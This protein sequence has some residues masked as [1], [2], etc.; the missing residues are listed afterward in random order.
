MTVDDSCV[1]CQ[2]LNIPT[3]F[4]EDGSNSKEM[5]THFRNSRWR[6]PP[7]WTLANMRFRFDSC[8]LCQILNIRIEF[9]EDWSYSKEIATQFWNSK[10]RRTQCWILVIMHFYIYRFISSYLYTFIYLY[11]LFLYLFLVNMHFWTDSCVHCQHLNN[12]IKFGEDWSNS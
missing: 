8:I 1:L 3:K 2:I 6:R 12:P 10:W 11:L 7:S 9:G 5:A 4:G